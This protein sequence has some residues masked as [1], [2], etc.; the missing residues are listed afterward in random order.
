MV[1]IKAIVIYYGTFF[2]HLTNIFIL[3]GKK[4][5]RKISS[6]LLIY[7]FYLKLWIKRR[8]QN[9]FEFCFLRIFFLYSFFCWSHLFNLSFSMR[10]DFT[11]IWSLNW[12]IKLIFYFFSV[13]NKNILSFTKSQWKKIL[14]QIQ[15]TILI[16]FFL[17]LYF[18]FTQTGYECLV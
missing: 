7:F 15:K 14:R 18:C 13:L 1:L 17:F 4:F 8:K 6:L 10:M 5:Y 11:W 3:K 16:S 12:E 9:S 2:L